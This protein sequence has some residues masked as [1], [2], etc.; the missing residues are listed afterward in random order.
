MSRASIGRVNTID[1][2]RMIFTGNL[3]FATLSRD[4]AGIAVEPVAY[5]FSPTR[6]RI[7]GL[8][9]DAGIGGGMGAA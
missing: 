4:P 1:S 8:E 6:A 9:A 5:T 2:Q 7:D 3:D